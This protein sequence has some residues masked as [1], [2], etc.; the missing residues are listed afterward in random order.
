MSDVAI[1]L[2]LTCIVKKGDIVSKM[3][4]KIFKAFTLAEVLITLGVIG[5]VS[6]MTM[7]TL[8]KKHQQQVAVTQL[9]KAYSELNQAI[10]FSEAEYGDIENWDWEQLKALE[11]FNKYFS[12]YI[13]IKRTILANTGIKYYQISGA[14][15]N[16]LWILQ[17][18][19]S[20]GGHLIMT[21][22]GYGLILDKNSVVKT[23]MTIYIDINGNK[24]PN[25]FG[26][27]VFVFGFLKNKKLL[28]PASW[29]DGKADN[30]ITDRNIL[31][32]GP[33]RNNYQCNKTGRGLWCGALIMHDGWKIAPDYPW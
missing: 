14:E 16:S 33:S 28:L 32:D 21:N 31:K 29:D 1:L 19:S 25:T 11:F 2:D 4:Q 6:A 18:N 15:E 7:P 13:K 23:I 26:K 5:V 22:S 3:F 17:D 24:G 9:K 10:K 30:P 8:V 12:H 27:D 20:R